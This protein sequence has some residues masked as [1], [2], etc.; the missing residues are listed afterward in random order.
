MK[1]FGKRSRRSGQSREAPWHL[2]LSR[3]KKVRML[4]LSVVVVVVDDDDD[5]DDDDDNNNDNNNNMGRRISAVT[6]DTRETDFLFRQ[7]SV[8]LQRG[9]A[10][11]FHDTFT[12]E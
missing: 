7:L 12:I 11:S 5:D 10:I 8:A 3:R 6:E 2:F 1:S 4:L 9:N